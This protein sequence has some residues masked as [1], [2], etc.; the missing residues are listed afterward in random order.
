MKKTLSILLICTLLLALTACGGS[1]VQTPASDPIPLSEPPT[2]EPV[3][4]EDPPGPVAEEVRGVTIPA[5]EVFVNGVSVDQDSMAAYPVYSVTATS[6]N[7]SGTESTAVYIGFTMRDVIDAAGFSDNYVWMEATADDGYSINLKGDIV[8]ADTTLL[9]ITKDGSPFSNAPWL[10]PCLD[11]VSG[12]YLK[13]AVSILVNTVDAPPD[14]THTFGGDS[15]LPDGLPEIADRTDM[16]EFEPYSFLI[17]GVEVTNDMLEGLSIFRITAVTENSAG[18]INESTYS[19]YRLASVLEVL[20]LSDATTVKAVAAD[21]FESVLEGD[22]IISDHTLIAIERDR[23]VG[24]NGT[25]WL[26]PCSETGARNYAR[27]VVEIIVE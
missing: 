22:L 23:E 11:A 13:G 25:V 9:A 8:L 18:E 6:V 27:D 1:Q 16:I 5:F 24:E 26:A 14:A 4:D 20:G 19:G 3:P 17:N 15:G 21:G 2:P 7:S 12:N 10:A